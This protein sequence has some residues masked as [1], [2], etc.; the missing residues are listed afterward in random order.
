MVEHIP[1]VELVETPF[2]ILIVCTGNI[3]RSPLA[4]QLLRARLAEAGIR[5]EILS[6]GT[7][8]M[9][10]NPMEPE[11]AALAVQL[12]A[13]PAPHVARQLT[14]PLIASADLVLTATREHR[15]EVVTLH[16]RA[17][18][19]AFTLPQFARLAAPHT[20][21]VEERPTESAASR[22]PRAP[23][24]PQAPPHN[25]LR[26]H[27]TT[28]AATRGLALPPLDPSTDDI[29][30]PYRQSPDVYARVAHLIDE[31]VTAVATSL[32]SATATAERSTP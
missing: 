31:T 23:Q 7:Q 20:P 27:I 3:C 19:Y 15:A 24:E 2:S 28:I 13:V 26:T 6:A 9:V 14:E 8:A 25:P 21:L 29:E 22:D 17:S 30:D 18:R 1:S 16:P 4:E 11:A 10:G 12:G 5:A 32:A